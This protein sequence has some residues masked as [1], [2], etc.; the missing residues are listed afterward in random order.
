MDNTPLY[1]INLSKPDICARIT[2]ARIPNTETL[3]ALLVPHPLDLGRPALLLQLTQCTKEDTDRVTAADRI[4]R[5]SEVFGKIPVSL[6]RF[7]RRE[8]Q[9]PHRLA[10]QDRNRLVNG[11]VS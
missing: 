2:N 4:L 6:G 8:T 1:L 3:A 10:V 9:Y 11:V 5:P 7:R